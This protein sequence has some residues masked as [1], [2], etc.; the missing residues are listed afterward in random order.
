MY[1]TAVLA[2][3]S[4]KINFFAVLFLG[5]KKKTCFCL[6]ENID[7]PSVLDLRSILLLTECKMYKPSNFKEL[8]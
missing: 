3:P 4:Q 1:L 6:K 2:I 8:V 7:N 5:T